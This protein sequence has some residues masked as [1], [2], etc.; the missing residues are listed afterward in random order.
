MRRALIALVVIAAVVAAGTSWLIG[1]NDVGGDAASGETAGPTA[2]A[3]AGIPSRPENAFPLTVRYV[4]DGDTIQA[5]MQ[6]PDDVVTTANPIRVRIVGIDTPEGAEPAE[7]WADDARSHLV[8]LLPEGSTA[9]AAPDRETWDDYQRRLF[10]LW[11]DDGRFVAHELVAAG[12]AEAIRVWPNVAFFDV[13]AEA[14]E[15]AL[16]AGVGQWGACG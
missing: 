4:Y 1:Q 7:C 16:A 6:T 9:W 15:R 11:T 12:D 5:Q 10:H 2:W 14:Q 3:G 13:L 8:T